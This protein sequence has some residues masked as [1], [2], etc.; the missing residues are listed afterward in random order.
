MKNST[1]RLL[2]LPSHCSQNLKS[3]RRKEEEERERR[4]ERRWELQGS[5][6]GKRKPQQA[7]LEQNNVWMNYLPSFLF[8]SLESSPVTSSSSP[9]KTDHMEKSTPNFFAIC[10]CKYESEHM[11]KR[12]RGAFLKTKRDRMRVL[13]L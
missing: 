13:V 4:K 10:K 1:C 8:W 2:S 3:K 6:N 12:E 7:I 5:C 9:T 11:G